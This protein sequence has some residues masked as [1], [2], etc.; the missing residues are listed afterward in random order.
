MLSTYKPKYI[1]VIEFDKF[2]YNYPF[3]NFTEAN[4]GSKIQTNQKDI[5]IE[6][7]VN[8]AKEEHPEISEKD[9]KKIK[10][11]LGTIEKPPI[12]IEIEKDKDRTKGGSISGGGGSRHSSNVVCETTCTSSCN[13]H[14]SC[15]TKCKTRCTVKS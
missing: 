8:V 3:N 2:N 6:S 9:V 13:I 7:V 11:P 12:K 4:L 5:K 1:A 15:T 10:K 14:G